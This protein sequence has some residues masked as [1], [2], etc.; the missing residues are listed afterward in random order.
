MWLKHTVI[1]ALLGS[2]LVPRPGLAQPGVIQEEAAFKTERRMD[3]AFPSATVEP[4]LATESPIDSTA[5]EEYELIQRLTGLSRAL[6]DF[7]SAYKD[8]QVDLKKVKAVRKAMQ[9][10]EK[11]EWFRPQKGK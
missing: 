1:A 11:S 3:V 5:Y 6:R 8:G 4:N 2:A 7:A 9:E 10:L